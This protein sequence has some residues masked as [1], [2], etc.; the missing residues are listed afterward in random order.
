MMRMKIRFCE[1]SSVLISAVLGGG[2]F[3]YS[4]Q[5][6]VLEKQN[7]VWFC[8]CGFCLFL[9]LR[10][11]MAQTKWG[12]HRGGAGG[13]GR[14]GIKEEERK[15]RRVVAVVLIVVVVVVVAVDLFLTDSRAQGGGGG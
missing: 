14:G 4:W 9:L 5:S 3:F 6:C 1:E 15:F 2:F 11:S 7:C 8:V 10:A 12:V 13:G